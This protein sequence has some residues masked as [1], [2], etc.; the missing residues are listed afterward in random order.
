MIKIIDG[1]RYNT[2]T[3]EKIAS[4]GNDLSYN[5]FN[6]WDE[7]LYCTKKGNWFL[8]GEG[9]AMSRY[10]KPCGNNGS[11]GGSEIRPISPGKAAK[12]LE[13][14]DHVAELEEHFPEYIEEA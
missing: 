14:H 10:S 13:E 9:G 1:K 7:R 8:H 6:Y 2:E 12:W 11:C 5:D 4:A 3:A